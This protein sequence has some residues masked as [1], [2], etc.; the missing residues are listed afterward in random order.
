VRFGLDVA[1][2]PADGEDVGAKDK[3][4]EDALLYDV[5]RLFIEQGMPAREIAARI[6]TDYPEVKFTRESVYLTLQKARARGL[7]RISVPAAEIERDIRDQFG[8]KD[9]EVTVVACA[10]SESSDAGAAVAAAEIVYKIIRAQCATQSSPVGL[11][12][13][14][15]R[16]TFNF[17]QVLGELLRHDSDVELNLY[18]ISAGCLPI[19]PEYAPASLFNL[20][21]PR[22]PTTKRIGM[23]AQPFVKNS[24]FK[25]LKCET[26]VSELFEAKEKDEISIVVTSM[27]NYKDPHTFYRLFMEKKYPKGSKDRPPW[28]DECVG[29]VQY[30]PFSANG[31]IHEREKDE[32]LVTLFEL[33]E[34]VQFAKTKGK[35]VVLIARQCSLCKDQTTRA[36]ALLPV[37]R[38]PKL[39]LFT[40][41]VLDLPT[42]REVIAHGKRCTT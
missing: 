11:G 7:I 31:P 1:E 17:S 22:T 23:F 37:L 42:A 20:F 33:E 2:L 13:G 9:E 32:R 8:L 24:E 5:A 39:R 19:A 41:L 4:L 21:P 34:L 35:S 28:L 25:E 3:T 38:N 6:T 29:D 15:G 30:R 27:G 36:E 14:P 10:N 40:H 12:L 18:G 26:G 16:A